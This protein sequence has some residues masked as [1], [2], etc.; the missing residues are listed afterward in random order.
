MVGGTPARSGLWGGGTWGIPGPGLDGGGY[1][2]PGLDGGGV[3]PTTM[4]RWGNP[5]PHQHSEH[6]LRGGRYASCVHAIGLSCVYI[7]MISNTV[8]S[9]VKLAFLS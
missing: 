3:S 8:A 1:P 9:R 2:I 7:I 6:L 4:T 5:P